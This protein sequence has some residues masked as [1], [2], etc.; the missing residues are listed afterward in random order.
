MGYSTAMKND[1]RHHTNKNI[2]VSRNLVFRYAAEL[3]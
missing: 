3:L 1:I 2:L